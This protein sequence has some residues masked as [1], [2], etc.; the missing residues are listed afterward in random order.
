MMMSVFSKIVLKN[1]FQKQEPKRL[2]ISNKTN[3]HR[4]RY[5]VIVGQEDYGG[6]SWLEVRKIPE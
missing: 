6:C 4:L 3:K 2:L 1:N 5:E